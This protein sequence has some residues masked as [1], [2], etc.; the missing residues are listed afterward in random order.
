MK[1]P[2]RGNASTETGRPRVFSSTRSTMHSDPLLYGPYDTYYCGICHVAVP[3][4]TDGCVVATR[5]PE[6]ILKHALWR[7]KLDEAARVE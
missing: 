7:L 1:T 5:T 6:Q 3:G 4:A 2:S